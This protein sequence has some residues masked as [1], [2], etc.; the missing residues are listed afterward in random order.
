MKPTRPLKHNEPSPSEKEKSQSSKIAAKKIYT[1]DIKK[2]TWCRYCRPSKCF[3]NERETIDHLIARHTRN[4]GLFCRICKKKV[5]KSAYRAH[6]RQ[7]HVYS[8]WICE[9]NKTLQNYT[10]YQQHVHKFHGAPNP[11]PYSEEDVKPISP[12]STSPTS[13]MAT[14]PEELEEDVQV[15]EAG[16][17][18]QRPHIEM[19]DE[20]NPNFKVAAT[21]EDEVSS[22][23]EYEI[24]FLPVPIQPDLQSDEQVEQEQPVRE[25]KKTVVQIPKKQVEEED[26]SSSES[27]CE[28]KIEEEVSQK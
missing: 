10:K 25:E 19:V 4:N 5:N 24:E 20:M 28:A 12:L 18:F 1:E 14:L 15:A 2:D 23:G 27:A 16:K 11:Q 17:G 21:Q 7:S 6:Y 26:S 3:P 9:C 8:D 13:P 22:E